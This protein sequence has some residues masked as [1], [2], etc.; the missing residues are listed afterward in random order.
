MQREESY[1]GFYRRKKKVG[2]FA[3][4]TQ[5][6]AVRRSGEGGK[7]NK[8]FLWTGSR[9]AQGNQYERRTVYQKIREHGY[10]DKR[11]TV[12]ALKAGEDRAIL[13]GL[14]MI[15]CSMMLYF[16]LG[17][18]ILRSYMESVWTEESW[19]TVL[20][21]TNI[22]DMTCT[23]SC[24]SDCY[25]VSKYPCLQVF[26]IL[27]SSGEVYRLSH[28]E[29]MLEINPECF[30]VPKCKKTCNMTVIETIA[31]HF[32]RH[33]QFPCFHDRERKQENVLLT[34]LY[35]PNALFHSLFWPTCMAV[36]GTLIIAMVKLTQ[37]LSLLCESISK[38]KR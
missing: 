23:F 37:Y 31:E 27:N 30:Y 7:F 35:G 34:R 24:G 22:G 18:T 8:M 6:S 33:Q 17:I 9:A 13:L 19:C 2:S 20:N 21:S 32:K 15:M 10:L 36:G 26:V 12:T 14:A 5:S 16:I 38:I 4:Q 28:T 25:E 29:E 3:H 1:I 11:K